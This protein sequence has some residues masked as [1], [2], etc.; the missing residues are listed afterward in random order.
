MNLFETMTEHEHEQVAFCYDQASGLKAIIAIHDTTLGPSLGGVRMW[1]YE[2]EEAALTDVLRLSKGMTYKNAA[3]GLNLGGGKAVIIGDPSI[4]S[5]ALYRALGRFI[6]SLGGRY[7]TAEDVNTTADDIMLIREETQFVSGMP[8][9]VGGAGDPSPWTA[10]GTLEGI[11]VTVA[12]RLGQHS[13]NG[14]RI[15]IQ[16]LGSV[17]TALCE[18]LHEEGAQLVV[19]DLQESRVQAMCENFGATA[20]S[21]DEIYGVETDVFVPCALG[22]VINDQ[23][24]T[25]F[26][27]A[28]IAGAANNQ[29]LDEHTHGPQLKARNILYAPDYIINAGGVINCYYEVIQENIPEIVTAKVKGIGDTLA[30]IYDIAE[31]EDIPTHQ[32]A[33]RFAENRIKTIG[34]VRS[35]FLGHSQ[36]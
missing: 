3:A 34:K 14:I 19:S 31:K 17:G 35:N 1:P 16:G 30:S 23:T 22:A 4:K 36:M 10:L 32:A 11:R 21:V 8:E 33:A 9:Y 15:A 24:L 28:A 2:S 25:Q 27:C 18:L 13:L 12:K 20:V 5:E 7:I 29:L 6:Q 26:R